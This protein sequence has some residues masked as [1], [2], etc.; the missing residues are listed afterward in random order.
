MRILFISHRLPYPP[1]HG[2]RIRAFNLIRHFAAR[3]HEVTLCSLFRATDHASATRRL[4]R[5]CREMH[6]VTVTETAQHMRMLLR[7][8]TRTPASLGYFYSPVLA[9]EIRH[10][11]DRRSFDLIFVHS[12]SVAQYVEEVAGVKKIID[13]TD[14]D[15]Q[16][17]LLYCNFKPTVPGLA[18]RLEGIKLAAE[19]KRLAR[20]F[21]VCTVATK[22]ELA[23]L[24]RLGGARVADW[25]SNGVDQ[26]YFK[27]DGQ[28]YRADAVSFVGR[29]DYYPNEECMI[30]FCGDV[31]PLLRK[32]IPAIMLNIVGANPTARVRRLAALEGVTVTGWVPDVRPYVLRSCA[33][34]APLA[35]ARG[36]QNKI[37]EAMAMGVPVVTSTEAA[38]GVD[39]R[40]DEHL[41]VADTPADSARAILRLLREP[42]E[43]RRI[44]EAGRARVLSHH[45]W[46]RSMRRLDAIVARCVDS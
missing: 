19:E 33:M 29:M 34:V 31:L 3:G 25:F 24:N 8:P 9:R 18:Y 39:A 23:T 15:S 7:L 10:A 40:A 17:W 5:Y 14:M 46:G 32:E 30:R 22:A 12:S 43:R 35:I 6:V 11:L 21:E 26:D 20:R 13:F 4:S 37:L 28:G 41:L 38:G 27:P 16:K 1:D 42:R 36:T 2:G 45:D 44:G